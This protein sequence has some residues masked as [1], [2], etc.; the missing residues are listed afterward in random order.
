MS[1]GNIIRKKDIDYGL[2]PKD[3][4]GYQIVNPGDIILRLTDLQND[5]KSLRTALVRERGIITSAYTCIQ[6]V[7][8]PRF[9]QLILHIYDITK[10]FYGLGGGVR[11]SIGYQELKDMLIPVPPIN[12]Q[13]EIVNFVDSKISL[14]GKEIDS[15]VATLREEIKLLNQY[16]DQ[17]AADIITGRT[18]LSRVAYTMNNE[19]ISEEDVSDDSEE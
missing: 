12:E 4:L 9:V 8:N 18:D 19:E 3:Y 5:H 16:K 15:I 17:M 6:T 7:Q 10:Y 13:E 11:Q 14:A 1:H 2:V